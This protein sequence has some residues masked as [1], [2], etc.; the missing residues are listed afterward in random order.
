MIFFSLKIGQL[1]IHNPEFGSSNFP[2]AMSYGE[3][4]EEI[5]VVRD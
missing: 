3:I 2:R 1:E 4:T 5:R